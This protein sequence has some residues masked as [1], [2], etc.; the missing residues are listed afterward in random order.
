MTDRS[1]LEGWR[2]R[3]AAPVAGARRTA[4]IPALPALALLALASL[5]LL[6]APAPAVAQDWEPERADLEEIPPRGIQ[7][8]SSG[9][10]MSLTGGAFPDRETGF[11]AN[12]GVRHLWPSGFSVGIGGIWA[13]PGD[14]DLPV[15]IPT[16]NM[17]L[18][19]AYVEGRYNIVQTGTLRP[20][21][22]ARAGWSRLRNQVGMSP[23]S[24]SGVLYGGIAG[25]EIWPT[26]RFAI[27]AGGS[28]SGLSASEVFREGETTTGLA[29]GVEL[30]VT[31][32]FG[33]TRRV[34]DTPRPLVWRGP[35]D[36]PQTGAPRDALQP[37]DMLRIGVWP[38]AE[39]GGEFVVEETGAVHLPMLGR[40]DVAGVS[41]ND[42]REQLREG[43][44]ELMRN[45]V[46]TVTPVFQ[47]GVLGAVRAP[48][49][50]QVT[51]ANSIIDVIGMAGGFAGGAERERVRLIRGGRA[52]E[53]DADRILEGGMRRQDLG[54]QSGDQII[55]P[56]REESTITFSNVVAF[57]QTGA[58]LGFL[59]S[60]ILR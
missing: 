27:R 42:L 33:S 4:S 51:P 59:I 24:G 41:L 12:M 21:V 31:Y 8:E 32:S 47:V 45:P 58:T 49:V 57:M 34:P 11:G 48:G 15:E 18:G 60:R 44:G 43:Y 1:Y 2:V 20:F 46:I 40:V 28:V 5:L 25:T 50:Y 10:W 52:I 13:E 23:G 3:P 16:Q 35:E 29:L 53:F 30:G 7:V 9:L 14:I 39:L 19:S 26:D 56:E 17:T 54:L 22:G 6:F 38:D 55:V 36:T 37:G